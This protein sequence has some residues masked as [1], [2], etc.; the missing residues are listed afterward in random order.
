MLKP[1]R[2]GWPDCAPAGPVNASE[3][4]SVAAAHP[5]PTVAARFIACSMVHPP[6][7]PTLGQTAL[8]R[9]LGTFAT[10][11]QRLAR[12]SYGG[13][14]TRTLSP[15]SLSRRDFPWAPSVVEVLRAERRK[16]I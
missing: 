14:G 9:I 11:G 5:K 3:G 8:S 12:R 16:S 6:L 15:V 7:R 1:I 10:A 13:S 2:I 4:V